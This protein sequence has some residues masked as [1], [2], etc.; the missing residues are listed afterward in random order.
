MA[1]EKD[2]GELGQDMQ[3]DRPMVEAMVKEVKER[4]DREE[5]EQR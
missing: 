4:K 5:R 1:K 3:Q 2:S